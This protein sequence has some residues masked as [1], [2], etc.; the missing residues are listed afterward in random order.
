[1]LLMPIQPIAH[2]LGCAVGNPKFAGPRLSSI[3]QVAQGQ[4]LCI[5]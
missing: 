1:L 5:D 2:G 4:G 3:R